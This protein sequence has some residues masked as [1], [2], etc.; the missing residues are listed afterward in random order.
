MGSAKV[1]GAPITWGVCEV[2]E[3]GYQLDVDRVLREMAELGI[4]ATEA[5]PDGFLP[6]E[7][8]RC[9]QI[10]GQKDL[11]LAAGFIPVVL[12]R[13]DTWA[14]ERAQASERI[15][16]LAEAGA[17][18]AVI[19]ASTGEEGYEG[20]RSLDEGDWDRL[21]HNLGEL[22]QVAAGAG[23]I[24]TVHPHY[25]TVIES[26]DQIDRFLQTSPAAVCLDTGHVMVGGGDPVD[27]T[28]KIAPRILHVHLKD[29]DASMAGRVSRGELS[30]HA[31]VAQGLYR[32]LGEG[33]VDIVAILAA[34]DE[35]GFEGWLVLEQDTVLTDEPPAKGGPRVQAEVSLRYLE[36]VAAAGY[37]GATSVNASDRRKET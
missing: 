13:A 9:R 17:D 22:E 33:D 11:T 28:R 18:V 7:L 23:V 8:D 5:G 26:P 34:L 3:W 6:A 29:V 2:P 20:T 27:L 37:V 4:T 31:A 32:P 1:A 21:S 15:R 35:A 24:L 12:H 30:Y 14:E 19:A 25:G 36:E 10:L 16:F